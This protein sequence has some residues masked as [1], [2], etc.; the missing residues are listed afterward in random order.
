MG[1][2]KL[3]IFAQIAKF[4]KLVLFGD[5]EDYQIMLKWL[6]LVIQC[7]KYDKKTGSEPKYLFF[8][9]TGGPICHQKCR[10]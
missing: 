6:D 1:F 5:T 7:R 9:K 8:G 2:T 4:P 10:A 3:N